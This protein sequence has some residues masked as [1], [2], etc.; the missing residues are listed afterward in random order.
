LGQASLHHVDGFDRGEW[1]DDLSNQVLVEQ[2]VALVDEES[3][4]QNE[5]MKDCVGGW[6][7]DET[8]QSS[9]NKIVYL[10]GR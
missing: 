7:V 10:K 2:V 5:V 1:G 8:F 4:R 6:I 3:Q 9:L